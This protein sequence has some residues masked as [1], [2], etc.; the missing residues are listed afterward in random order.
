MLDSAH[1]IDVAKA[2][3]LDQDASDV[4]LE[5]NPFAGVFVPRLVPGLGG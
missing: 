5:G 4:S 3:V 2:D 1:P